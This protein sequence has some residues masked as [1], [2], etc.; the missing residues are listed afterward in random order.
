MREKIYRFMQGRYGNDT[1]N[2]VL[3]VL[4][5]IFLVLNLF[6]RQF[7]LELIGLFFWAVVIFRMFSKNTYRRYQENQSFMNLIAPITKYK[8]L[9]QK[10]RQ[11]PSH[12]YYR[13]PSC[14][15]IVR[16]PKGHGKVVVTCP[17]CQRQFEKRT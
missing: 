7:I 6:T 10:R 16:L 17:K 5:I 8:T 15:Q 12:K 1:L 13:C 14:H 2:N 4:C 9:Q 11:D 3:M